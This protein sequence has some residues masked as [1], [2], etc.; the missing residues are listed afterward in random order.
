MANPF[1]AFATVNHIPLALGIPY[2]SLVQRDL[3]LVVSGSKLQAV[4]V[5]PA[6]TR[7]DLTE[8][9]ASRSVP[10]NETEVV[11]GPAIRHLMGDLIGE[12]EFS[13]DEILAGIAELPRREFVFGAS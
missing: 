5:R 12:Q 8:T 13:K 7:R 3:V 2:V 9:R 1:A 4:A 6:P 10:A 11:T